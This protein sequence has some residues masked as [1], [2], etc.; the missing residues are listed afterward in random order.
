MTRIG[1]LSFAHL[2]AH[3][4]AA[5]L[6]ALPG[7]GL[8]GVWDDDPERGNEAA[9][10][11]GAPFEPSL[12]A[13]LASGLEGVIICAENMAHRRLVEAAA[14]AGLWILCEKPLAPRAQDAKA[15]IAA[16]KKARVGLGTA[17]PCRFVPPL[18]AARDALASGEYGEVYAVACTNHGQNPG[19]WFNDPERAGGGAV[20][21]H[22]VHVADLLRWMLG[23]EFTHVYCEAGNQ[24]H[25]GALATDDIGSMHLEMQGGVQVSHLASWSRPKSFPT[26][27]DVTMEFI[28]EN[29]V[30]NLDAFN[31]KLDHY[32]EALGRHVYLPWGDNADLAL[33]QDFAEAARDRRAP[34]VTGLDGLRATEVTEAA[35]KSIRTGKRVKI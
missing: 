9:A 24:F 29:G 4:Y 21:D 20:M 26:W 31:Q 7:A 10:Q 15:M 13:F 28:C 33:V 5:A 18:V 3:G 16:C 12:E 27:G 25:G 2:H 6:N 23:R 19:G 17:F 34:A 22:T 1:I 8:A 14:E 35:Y 32:G 30:I 11:Y